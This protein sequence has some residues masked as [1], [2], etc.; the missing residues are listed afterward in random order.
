MYQTDDIVN[1]I[2]IK[3]CFKNLA[4]LAWETRPLDEGLANK[5]FDILVECLGVDF[6]ISFEVDKELISDGNTT[7][8]ILNNFRSPNGCAS[9]IDSLFNNFDYIVQEGQFS[10]QYLA[11][12]Q[13]RRTILE[14]L[15]NYQNKKVN[16]D[17]SYEETSKFVTL[18]NDLILLDARISLVSENIDNRSR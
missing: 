15:I 2:T 7:N 1:G 14:E 5:F 17:G 12:L 9:M 18:S 10:N 16:K 11:Y 3:D 8:L 13:N 4:E 6:R